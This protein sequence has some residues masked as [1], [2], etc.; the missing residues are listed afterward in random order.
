MRLKS[1][2]EDFEVNTLAA[3][4]GLLGKLSYLGHLH[5][6]EGAYQH[7]GLEKVY[8]KDAARGAITTCHR[9]LVARIL[10]TPLPV[11]LEDVGR[12][13][14]NRHLATRDFLSSLQ[15]PHS[16]P[17]S[18]PPA[19]QVHFNSVLHALLA[20]AERRNSANPRNA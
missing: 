8:G 5:D 20:L 14:A 7:W 11:L 16:L 4:P 19:A 17:K 12:S 9:A 18:P 10:K 13:S 2:L 3:V 6:G 1:A 15:A